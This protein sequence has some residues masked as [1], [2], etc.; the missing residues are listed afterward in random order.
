MSFIE[1]PYKFS[2]RDYQKSI[3]NAIIR[4]NKKHALALWHRRAGKTKVA[5]NI[6]TAAAMRRVGLYV[7][8]LPQLNQ[9]RRSLWE[10]RGADGVRFIDHIPGL[11]VRKVNNTEMSVQ[12]QNGSLIR[13]LGADRYDKLMG[14]NCLGIIYDEFSL[15]NPYARDYLVPILAENEGFEVFIYTPRGGNHGYTLYQQNKENEDWYVESLTVDDTRRQNGVPVVT[16]DIIEEFKRTG[17]SED[18]IQQEFYCSFE[19]AVTGAYFAKQLQT[20]QKTNRIVTFPLDTNK[21]IY[22]VWDIGMRDATAIWFF[23][24]ERDQVYVVNYYENQGEALPHYVNYIHNYRESNQIMYGKHIAPHDSAKRNF[25]DG[26][27]ILDSAREMG[28]TFYPLPRYNN[29]AALIEIAR[30]QFS[31]LIFHKDYCKRGL[32]CLR[33]YHA[34]YNEAMG[35]FSVEPEH[36]WSSHGADAFQYLCQYIKEHHHSNN[37]PRILQ[38]KVNQSSIF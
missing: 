1:L 5:F 21:P 37:A 29:K 36:N 11:L 10:A 26:K 13:L 15:Q 20:A 38:N 25:T 22:T 16:N 6:L 33:E 17:W 32:D 19:A 2:P 3:L 14:I 23:Q 9:A 30:G 8:L 24:I 7:Y 18:K 4:D 34:K 28:I 27:T 31:K 12:L 35:V